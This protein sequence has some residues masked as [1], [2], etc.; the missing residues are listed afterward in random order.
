MTYTYQDLVPLSVYVLLDSLYLA[1]VSM[2][3][4]SLPWFGS[5]K[6]KH[7]ISSPVAR[8]NN[9]KVWLTLCNLTYQVWVEIVLFVPHYHI[10]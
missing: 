9:Y 5:V 6:P 1:R 4:G 10:H 8:Q 3:P 7:P 2:P